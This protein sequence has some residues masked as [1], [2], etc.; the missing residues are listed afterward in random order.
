MQGNPHTHTHIYI[1][2]YICILTSGEYL[3]CVSGEEERALFAADHEEELQLRLCQVLHFVH[4]DV[5][6][7][8]AAVA[9]LLQLTVGMVDRVHL[10]VQTQ[11]S[12][13]PLDGVSE[14]S[15]GRIL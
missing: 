4:D 10:V 14:R 3:G 1:Y 8:S 15:Q 11:R 6:D 7:G 9:V 2:I 12:L 13:L 5:V